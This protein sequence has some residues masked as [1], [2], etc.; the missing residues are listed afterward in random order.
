MALLSDRIYQA[1]AIPVKDGQ[2]CV[3]KSSSHKRWIIPKGC[4]EEGKTVE[5]IALQEA[6]EEAGLVGVLDAEPV[7]TYSYDKWNSTCHVTVYLMHVTKVAD[8]YPECDLR[9]RVWVSPAQALLR[10]NTP[11]LNEILLR[12]LNGERIALQA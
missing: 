8:D 5:E 11:G 10:I 9:E 3:V 6:W 4:L 7:G 1:A 12:V 2:I